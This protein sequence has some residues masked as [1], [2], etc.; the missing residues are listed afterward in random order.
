MSYYISKK[1][2][3][4]YLEAIEKTKERL[5]GQGFGVVS[6]IDMQAVFKNKI[7]KDQHDR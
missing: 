3:Y 7:D 2:N 6:E 1:V 4:P 5:K